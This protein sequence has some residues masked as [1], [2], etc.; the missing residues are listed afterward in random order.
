TGQAL[1][2]PFDP[3]M[4]VGGLAFVGG[5]QA[6]WTRTGE[7]P[8]RPPRSRLWE[9]E[10]GRPLSP[11]IV[12]SV[13]GWFLGEAGCWL[14]RETAVSAARDRFRFEVIDAATGAPRGRAFEYGRFARLAAFSPD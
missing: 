9:A 6:L 12:G 7:L 13:R 5:S 11:V 14:L 1:G 10:T 4:D 3:G 2:R 8:G